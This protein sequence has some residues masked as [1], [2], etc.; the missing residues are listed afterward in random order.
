ML[1][2][3]VALFP[4]F[5]VPFSLHP[6]GDSKQL[7]LTVTV[8][9]GLF[10][11]LLHTMNKGSVEIVKSKALVFLGLF[12][13]WT[14][15][16]AL[17]SG[18]VLTSVFGASTE[19]VFSV[20]NIILFVLLTVLVV[21][22]GSKVGVLRGFTRALVVSFA[23]LV[24]LLVVQLTNLVFDIDVLSSVSTLLPFATVNALAVYLAA[25]VVFLMGL[26]VF[27]KER[28]T[29]K[30]TAAVLGTLL[31]VIVL[32]LGYKTVLLVIALSLVLLTSLKIMREGSLA[33]SETGVLSIAFALVVLFY[34]AP[35]PFIDNALNIPNEIR[36]SFLAT[37]TIGQEMIVDSWWR[38]VLGSGPATFAYT[39][40]TYKDPALNYT[41]FWQANFTQGFSFMSTLP[42]NVGLV[43]L[44][45]FGGF[46]VVVGIEGFRT[47]HVL[48]KEKN[49]FFSYAAAFYAL[50]SY[51]TVFSFIYPFD[52]GLM[53]LW[54]ASSALVLSTRFQR[55]KGE[56][57]T[58]T[59]SKYPE[60]AFTTSFA[61]FG[62]MLVLV[63]GVYFLVGRYAAS[64]QFARAASVVESD[65]EYAIS[66]IQ[67]GLKLFSMTGEGYRLLAQV[68]AR[69]A[70]DALVHMGEGAND[71]YR[72]RFLEALN[73]TRAAA[74]IAS[75]KNS[76]DASNYVLL[77]E[78][79]ESLIPYGEGNED[80]AFESYNRARE[81]EPANPVTLFTLGRSSLMLAQK[82]ENQRVAAEQQGQE[83]V[84]QLD[85]Q[86]A[87]A[88]NKA[89]E[90]LTESIKLKNDF[91]DA[92]VLLVQVYAASG[93]MVDAIDQTRGLLTAFPQDVGFAFQ[94]G[95]LYFA[96]DQLGEAEQVLKSVVQ[97]YEDH[98]NA[99]YVLG[100]VYERQGD[101]QK[102]IR[103]FE[104]VIKN[105][106]DNT[107]VR[108]KLQQLRQSLIPV[109]EEEVEIVEEDA[110]IGAEEE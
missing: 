101:T 89:E 85:A 88:Y 59:F 2:I 21:I 68:H 84:A 50:W 35:I 12:T 87:E 53:F 105:N 65:T 42:I 8:F 94:L 22:A 47:L 107:E 51:I 61:L 31:F 15:I 62:V 23:L 80:F 36:P 83:G 73:N 38:G 86:I 69:E 67:S 3:C 11:W 34:I 100:L 75:R 40:Q 63:F 54:L 98:S 58:L 60:R 9:L 17:F 55:K 52:Y 1:Y 102:A 104:G 41:D 16:G 57:F 93:K 109:V 5:I 44:V 74:E 25:G 39:Y 28:N 29:L 19:G 13:G 18:T 106:P 82:R 20:V 66:S 79:Y 90:Y 77:G 81:L 108:G 71:A 49:E 103:Q 30:V 37:R 4:A 43:G 10:F 56:V 14:L 96:N 92:H 24:L 91:L 32:L 99:L 72:I 110:E 95:Y 70:N 45:F 27:T 6:L 97:V 76:R 46:L 64:I 48:R 26:V 78:F 7:L 33:L